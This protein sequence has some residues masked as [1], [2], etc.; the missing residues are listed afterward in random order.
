M[1][2][3]LRNLIIF[4]IIQ[5]LEMN[6]MMSGHAVIN[7]VFITLLTWFPSKIN[8]QNLRFYEN[9]DEESFWWQGWFIIH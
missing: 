4:N 1:F 7:I 2:S 3:N 9:L 6:F 8:L 5:Q